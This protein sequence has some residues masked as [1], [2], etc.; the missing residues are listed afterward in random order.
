M[1]KFLSGDNSIDKA[2]SYYNSMDINRFMLRIPAFSKHYENILVPRRFMETIVCHAIAPYLDE[3]DEYKPPVYLAIQGSPGEGKTAQSIAACTQKGFDVIYVSASSLSGSHENEA[4]EKLQK[5]YDYA[6]QASRERMAVIVIDDF[7]KGIVNE[8]KNIKKTINSDVLVGYMMNI[9]EYNASCHI[10]IILTANDLSDIYAPLLRIGRADIFLWEPGPEEKREVVFNILSFVS[11]K[12]E[13]Q[14]EL[15][16]QKY[17]N[18]NI[19]F[20]AQLKNQWRK[21]LLKTLICDI[22]SFHEKNVKEI[23]QKIK[24]SKDQLTYA[25]L[26]VLADSLVRERG[27]Q[28]CRA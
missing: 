10:P 2:I 20:F 25:E 24:S 4:R 27:E 28:Q 18:E 26:T 5:I 15:F 19:A 14:L 17:Q 9:A 16:Y 23:N 11:E 6:L 7:H 22:T 21:G 1:N 3:D 12:N 8:D 13:D